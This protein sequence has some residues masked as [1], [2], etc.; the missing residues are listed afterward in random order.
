MVVAT[1]ALRRVIDGV[2]GFGIKFLQGFS[3]DPSEEK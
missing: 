3:L 1:W 2:G